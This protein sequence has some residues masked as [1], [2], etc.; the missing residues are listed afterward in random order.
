VSVASRVLTACERAT[1]HRGLRQEVLDILA[2]VVRFDAHVWLLTDPETCV[3]SSPHARV[4]SMQ[5]LPGLIR[6]KYLEH[7]WTTMPTGAVSS[8]SEVSSGDEGEGAWRAHLATYGVCDVAATVCRDDFGCWAFLDLW[9]CGE[10]F[11]RDELDLLRGALGPVPSALRRCLAGSFA[12]GSF[13][14]GSFASGSFA[15]GSFASGSTDRGGSEPAVLLLSSDLVV[16]HQTPATEAYLRALLPTEEERRPVP[17]AAYNVAAQLLAVEAGVDTRPAFSRVS[18]RP[19]QWLTLRAARLTTELGR[20]A[21]DDIAVTIERSSTRERLSMFALVH[22]LT[23]REAV[24][25]ECLAEGLDTRQVAVRLHLSEFTVQDHLK[26]VFDKTGVRS[27]SA[28][29]ARAVG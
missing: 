14:S 5:D 8:W 1:D 23:P 20:A 26:S 17:A 10:P 9:R 18:L 12:S 29:L 24:V 2:P 21:S 25:L 13:A 4:P 16:R 3:G 11:H 19:G 28:L 27:R 22:A 6:L 7:G 15:S